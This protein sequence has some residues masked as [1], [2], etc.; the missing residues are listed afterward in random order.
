MDDFMAMI[1]YFSDFQLAILCL[2]NEN[3]LRIS[4]AFQKHLKTFMV[5]LKAEK[6]IDFHDMETE[7]FIANN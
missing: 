2:S 5:Q 1:R 6:F 7:K 3:I 4:R